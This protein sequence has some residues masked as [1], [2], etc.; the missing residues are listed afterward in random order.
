VAHDAE[1]IYFYAECTTPLTESTDANWMNLFVDVDTKAAT[2]WAGY[3]VRINNEG[4]HRNTA[5]Q[6]DADQRWAWTKAGH[7]A[8]RQVSGNTLQLVVPRALLGIPAGAFT[9]DFKLTDNLQNPGDIMDLYL[10]GDVAPEGRYN[11]RYSAQ[12]L[13]RTTAP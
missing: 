1:N 10:S 3:D 13:T 5:G 11:Y 12:G 7:V 8:G 4:V 9:I 2:G 6:A